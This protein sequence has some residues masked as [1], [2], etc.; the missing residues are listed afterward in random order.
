MSPSTTRRG[1]VSA[2]RT[3]ND[4]D[5]AVPNLGVLAR[6]RGD[7]SRADSLAAVVKETLG[8]DVGTQGKISDG[9]DG[10]SL[11]QKKREGY[12]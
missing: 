9:E 6:D 5:R 4:E 7:E 2:G 10:G 1:C 12:F 3:N 8:Q 11:E